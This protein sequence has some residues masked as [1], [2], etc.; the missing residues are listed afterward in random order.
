MF[1]S[2]DERGSENKLSHV[3]IRYLRSESGKSEA[4]TSC[5]TQRNCEVKTVSK[6]SLRRVWSCPTKSDRS[7]GG[8]PL[9]C[10]CG[11]VERR[12]QQ[13]VGAIC[14][15]SFFKKVYFENSKIEIF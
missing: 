1:V 15:Y 12:D 11:S 14:S 10:I 4:L 8:E 2:F 3:P 5:L 7:E 6:R 9:P 13:K